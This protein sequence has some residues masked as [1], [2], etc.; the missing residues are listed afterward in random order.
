[1]KKILFILIGL[2]FLSTCQ[3]KQ[4]ALQVTPGTLT[5]E[6][7]GGD[8]QTLSISTTDAWTIKTSDSWLHVSPS[9]G[10]SSGSVNVVADVYTGSDSRTATITVIGAGNQMVQ[11][12][13]NG[14]SSS[15]GKKLSDITYQLLVYS[16]ADS[17]GDGW[18]D[19]K[20]VT[21]H[22]DYLDDLGVSALW[23][24]PIQTAASYHGYDIL[25]YSSIDPRLGTEAD[26]QELIDKAKEKGIDIYMDYV[27]NH[28]GKGE[29]FKSAIAS[30]DSP[31]RSFYV[32][33]DNPSA[34]VAAGKVDNYAGASSPGMG[35]W[36][37]ASSGD[38]GYKGR[39]HI[40]VDMGAKTVTVTETTAAAQEPN[41]SGAKCWLWYGSIAEHCGL[42]ENGTNKYEITLD[43]DTDWGFL[44]CTSTNWASGTKWGGNGGS[45]TFG[46]PFPL[47]N[48]TAADIT[49]GGSSIQY[50]SS[51]DK[52]MPDLNYGPYA[53]ASESSAFKALAESA[54]KWVNM[55]VN[56]LRLDAVLW[57]YQD[58][59]AANWSFLKQWYDRINKTYKARGG[60]GN[61]Y[62]VGEAFAEAGKVA[63]YYRGLPS[64]FN[65]SFWWTVKD[66]IEKGKGD[67]FAATVIY[68]RNL[69]KDQRQDFIDAIKLSNHDEDRT[70]NDLG[71]NVAK[72]KL[73]GAVLLTSPGKPYIY[74]GEEL[75]YWGSKS[76]DDAYIR[77]PIKWTR[78]GSV[79]TAALGGKVDRNMLESISVEDQLAKESSVLNVYRAFTR[80]R[81]SSVAL[82]SGDIQA[83]KSD[84][85]GIGVWTRS[86][87]GE[88]VLVAHNFS[89]SPASVT[90]TNFKLSEK[91]VS[92]GAVSVS[93]SSLTLGAYSSVV[94]KQ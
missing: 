7:I 45:I 13:Q 82:S 28:S 85:E 60:E 55:G 53:K 46:E 18:G 37:T 68:F 25:D 21:Q 17:D 76:S 44:V 63:P 80:A 1:M 89:G 5:F 75:G 48:T 29:W 38:L 86:Y 35:S 43:M 94:F 72:E 93:G 24:S 83:V 8:V 49:F 2:V 66:R 39:L 54:D 10:M 57:I 90:L 11:V 77:T 64:N 58:Q 9:A 79:P 31:Y 33:S 50:F 36:Y 62:M 14:M 47:N 91:L 12:T 61:I 26:F 65:F 4:S 78:S 3:S 56:G 74:Q 42:Y 59:T 51:F 30:E 19:L 20:G 69:F 67:D 16:F 84:A 34:D 32:L 27:L 41:K 73:A 71:R 22:L 87:S 6:A 92:N 70:G 88:K 52:S 15:P 23:L 81:N 40:E